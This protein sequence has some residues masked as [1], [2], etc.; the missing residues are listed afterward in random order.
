MV[1][2]LHSCITIGMIRI[3]IC[4]ASR[5]DHVFGYAQNGAVSA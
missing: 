4:I 3:L 5:M 2:A 1:R